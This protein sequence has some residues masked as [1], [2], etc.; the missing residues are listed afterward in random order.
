MP[1]LFDPDFLDALEGASGNA[2]IGAV[3]RAVIGSTGPLRTNRL[4]GRWNPPGVE[5]LYCALSKAGAEAE[6]AAVIQRQSVP[7]TKPV[8]TYRLSV[9]LSNVCDLLKGTESLA[10]AGMTREDLLNDTWKLPQ[11]IGEAAEWLGVGGLLVP[12]AR[13]DDGNLVVLV[14]KLGD[15]DFFEPDPEP[16]AHGN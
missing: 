14:N 10:A 5:V 2:W 1:G 3:W 11:R 6:L 4:G 16:E 7:I 13:H 12:S 8:L 15:G 9:R